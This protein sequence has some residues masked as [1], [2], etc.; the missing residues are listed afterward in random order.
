MSKIAQ[1]N[2]PYD[3]S[4]VLQRIKNL[5]LEGEVQILFHAQERMRIRRLDM[6]DVQH[7]LRYGMIT[8]ITPSGEHWRYRIEGKTVDGKR[9]GYVV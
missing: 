6:S 4:R 9:A 1:M 2:D 3:K 8:E 7:A 5:L